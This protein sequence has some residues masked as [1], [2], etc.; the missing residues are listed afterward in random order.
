MVLFSCYGSVSWEKTREML[1]AILGKP[2]GKEDVGHVLHLLAQKLKPTIERIK[3]ALWLSKLVFADETGYRVDGKLAW[4]HS[5]CNACFTYVSIQAKR[6]L[7][8][9]TE[10][11]FLEFCDEIVMTDCWSSYFKLDNVTH[12]LC[13][14]HLLRELFGAARFMTGN[15]EWASG[16]II[17]LLKMN[18]RRNELIREGKTEFPPEE[19]EA[20]HREGERLI[21]MGIAL[22]PIPEKKEG[23]RGR[24]AKG[25][26]RCLL[27]RTVEHRDAFCLFA[28][29]LEVSFTRIT[30]QNS[31]FVLF[32]PIPMSASA[33]R[34]G[35]GRETI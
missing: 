30:A 17:L 31:L 2:V 22:N 35:K 14:A 1:E 11:E 6:G 12:G 27:D 29:N 16:L 28:E 15:P 32:R 23:T 9:M 13:N 24:Q 7:E 25:K 10:A 3:N 20:F 26:V 5:A 19:K 18:D 21:E 4:V 33:S 8:E 34:P